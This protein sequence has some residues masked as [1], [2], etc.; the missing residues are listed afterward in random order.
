MIRRV[1]PAN[2]DA[3]AE[4]FRD[5]DRTPLPARIGVRSRTLLHYHGLYL[6]LV[7]GGPSL[8]ENMYASRED[9]LFREIDQRMAELLTP[10]DSER[11]SM[12][13]AQA[14]EFYHWSDDPPPA[15]FR[16]LLEFRVDSGRGPEYERTWRRLI[17]PVAEWPDNLAQSISRDRTDPDTFYVLSD[18][19]GEEAFQRF[20]RSP[21]HAE[22]AEAS[23]ALGTP[24]RVT[25]M[26]IRPDRAGRPEGQAR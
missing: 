20:L 1:D 18:W 9:P 7:E 5:H 6:H 16:V 14:Q 4:A 22:L 23:R 26:Y 24:A 10:Y 2:L 21:E 19:T 8:Q 17:A 11:P 15:T 13:E 25:H 3:V 12:R